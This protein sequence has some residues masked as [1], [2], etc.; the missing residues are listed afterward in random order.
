M[1][2]EEKREQTILHIADML[3]VTNFEVECVVVK[4]PKGIKITIEVSQ[5]Q[6]NGA[7]MGM[8][9]KEG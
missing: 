7:I 4:N 9:K 5:E 6:M 3:R 1:N 8:K 2:E